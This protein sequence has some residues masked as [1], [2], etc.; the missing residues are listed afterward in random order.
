[1]EHT[2]ALDL[3]QEHGIIGGIHR[4]LDIVRYSLDAIT[5]GHT[6]HGFRTAVPENFC[7]LL[8][9]HFMAALFRQHRSNHFHPLLFQQSL[10]FLDLLLAAG[11]AGSCTVCTADDGHFFD[12]A[13]HSQ[14]LFHRF[15][16]CND[17]T[18]TPVKI[19]KRGIKHHCWHFTPLLKLPERFPA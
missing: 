3:T 7:F 9:Q 14:Q 11:L 12:I 15:F 5:A 4:Q 16:L 18:H 8:H 19:Q 2:H 6:N 10:H 1:M 17:H 13:Q